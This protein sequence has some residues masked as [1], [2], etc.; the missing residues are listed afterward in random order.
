MSC[1]D[2]LDKDLENISFGELADDEKESVLKG[3]KDYD[4]GDY[5]DFDDYIK[6]RECE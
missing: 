1:L 4:N 5:I 6:Q 3:R 2:K